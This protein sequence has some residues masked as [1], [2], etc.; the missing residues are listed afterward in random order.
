MQVRG[1]GI[2]TPNLPAEDSADIFLIEMSDLVTDAN[3]QRIDANGL[4]DHVDGIAFSAGG[5][6]A[7]AG[8]FDLRIVSIND[9]LMSDGGV[10]GFL[11]YRSP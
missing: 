3:S 5:S 1:S 4:A 6:M 10:D 11:L 9:V 8:S 7:L 2:I